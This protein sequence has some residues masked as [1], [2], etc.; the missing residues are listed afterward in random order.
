MKPR[1]NIYKSFDINRVAWRFDAIFT[2]DNDP[3]EQPVPI[4]Q[5][6]LDGIYQICEY[7]KENSEESDKDFSEK[8]NVAIYK[9]RCY[10]ALLAHRECCDKA[11]E[12]YKEHCDKALKE[13]REIL[14]NGKEP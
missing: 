2:P 11:L 4:N 1:I 12:A 3:T 13:Y 5:S 6:L 7:Y 14:F 8:I 9:E 10:Q